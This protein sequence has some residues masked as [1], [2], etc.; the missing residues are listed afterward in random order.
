MIPIS[1]LDSVAG[2]RDLLSELTAGL[3]LQTGRLCRIGPSMMFCACAVDSE[4]GL[5][6]VV[7]DR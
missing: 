7:T 1:S 4:P 3:H 2:C 6:D 5:T